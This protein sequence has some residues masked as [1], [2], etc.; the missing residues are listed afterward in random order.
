[1]EIT[2]CDSVR[3]ARMKSILKLPL[4]IAAVV[5][6]QIA[7]AS[8][9]AAQLQV[10]ASPAVAPGLGTMVRGTTATTFTVSTTG[11]VTQTSGNGIRI[12]NSG[13]TA[14]TVTISC[15]LLNLSG[16]CALRQVR[17][18]IQPVTNTNAQITKFYVGTILGNIIMATGVMPTPASSITFDL[19]PLGLLG[20]GSF[21]LGMDIFTAAGLTSGNYNFDYMVTAAFI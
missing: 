4:G 18:T 8:P 9:A 17:V 16:L 12:S 13:V 3:M 1:M 20:T 14:P 11:S 7:S 5:I 21:T 6:C 2:V 10:S 15:G 19:K